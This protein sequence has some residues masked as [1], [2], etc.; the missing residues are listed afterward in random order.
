[1]RSSF[2]FHLISLFIIELRTTF[3]LSAVVSI[4]LF[5]SHFNRFQT[6]ESVSMC[7]KLSP[8]EFFLACCAFEQNEQ[9]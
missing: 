1:M 5:R 7:A 6:M 9:K 3:G 8:D 4:D 2:L